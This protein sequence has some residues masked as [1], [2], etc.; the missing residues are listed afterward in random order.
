M[1]RAV[2]VAKVSAGAFTKIAW[3]RTEV[4]IERSS[5]NACEGPPSDATALADNF[6]ENV[7]WSRIM[8]VGS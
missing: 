7:K 5:E 1:P 2:A 8:V 4:H 6:G 3:E